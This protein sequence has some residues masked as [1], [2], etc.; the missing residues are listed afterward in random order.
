MVSPEWELK[1]EISRPSSAGPSGRTMWG[2]PPNHSSR[3]WNNA[4]S[5]CGGGAGG[6]AENGSKVIRDTGA[7]AAV[8]RRRGRRAD[9]EG[10]RRFLTTRPASG[11][12]SGLLLAIYRFRLTN[13]KAS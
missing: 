8:A 2:C 1:K 11:S 6:K 10:G 5:S 9:R 4:A 3:G 12:G 7:E 13:S